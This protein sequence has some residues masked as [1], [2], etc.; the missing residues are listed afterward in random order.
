MA[1]ITTG[2]GFIRNLEKFGAL[3]VYVPLEGGYEGRYLRRLRA[4]GYV[5]LHITARG[6]GD[7]AAYLMQVHGV[8]PPHLGKRSNSSGAAVGDVYYLPPMI[9]S[10]LAQL[11]PKSKGLVLWIIEGNILSDQEVEYLMN[12]PKLEPRVK[13]VIERGGDRIFRWTPLEK[14]LLAS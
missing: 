9:S 14:T 1:L 13:V 8:R 4:T 6:L 10:H 2:N 5:A 11:P 12:L 7:V 3:G